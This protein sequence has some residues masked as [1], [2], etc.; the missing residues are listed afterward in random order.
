[1]KKNDQ[2]RMVLKKLLI[3]M[4]M[5]IIVLDTSSTAYAQS[6]KQTIE[7]IKILVKQANQEKKKDGEISNKT[8]RKLQKELKR[9]DDDNLI[10][11]NKQADK[12][13]VITLKGS[14]GGWKDLGYKGWKYRVD[15]P[16]H[17]G[18]S[19]PHVHVKGKSGKKI[20]EG[21]EN[22]DGTPS[23]GKTLDD[24]KIPKK[25][26]DKARNTPEYQKQKKG[27]KKMK[28]AKA[29]I[30]AKDLNL[31]KPNELLVAIAIVVIVVGFL[32]CAPECLP[33]LL[34]VV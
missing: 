29:K 18:D 31:D 25:V 2:A 14:S 16:E 1:M 32:I 34:A 20:V 22:V 7:N 24:K 11:E 28:R 13:D 12:G 21:V 23:H 15:L 19:K 30:E 5:C 27:L 3:F 8:A 17:G 10:S 6:R 4:L 9:I 26:R 33:A